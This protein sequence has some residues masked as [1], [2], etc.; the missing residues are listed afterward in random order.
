MTTDDRKAPLPPA[1]NDPPGSIGSIVS[2]AGMKQEELAALPFDKAVEALSQS[3]LADS[4]SEDQEI[5]LV[6]FLLSNCGRL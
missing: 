2:L 4:L 6:G 3:D 5:A 1:H